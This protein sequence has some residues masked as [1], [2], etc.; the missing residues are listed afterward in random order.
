MRLHPERKGIH[1]KI[2]APLIL[3]A[4][5]GSGIAIAAEASGSPHEGMGKMH[6]MMSMMRT[7]QSM[8]ANGDQM[9][10]KEEFTKAHEAMFD[11]L[12]KNQD[13]LVS[14]KDMPCM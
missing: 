5:L 4:A 3:A 9:V 8:D 7:M 2:T 10:S 1:M 12:K 14:I 13:G 6:G 11:S